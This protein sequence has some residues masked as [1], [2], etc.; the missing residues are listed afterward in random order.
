MGKGFNFR[1]TPKKG[2]APPQP[3]LF[4]WSGR[5]IHPSYLATLSDG[6]PPLGP[7]FFL[8][9]LLLGLSKICQGFPHQLEGLFCWKKEK[10]DLEIPS[11]LHLLDNLERAQSHSF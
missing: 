2:V 4:L 1:Q 3:L 11:T 8:N 10:K 6:Q 9:W 5:G 7:I